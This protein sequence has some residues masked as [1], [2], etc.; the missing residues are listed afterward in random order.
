MKKGRELLIV[1]RLEENL[2]IDGVIDKKLYMGGGIFQFG[3]IDYY[4]FKIEG[5]QSGRNI[6]KV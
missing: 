6:F 5:I 4:E 1:Y 2:F 3:R